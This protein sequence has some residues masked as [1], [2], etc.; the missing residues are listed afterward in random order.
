[1][2]FYLLKKI[3]L[4]EFCGRVSTHFVIC[5]MANTSPTN[6]A[7]RGYSDK[8]VE[9]THS[10]K[11]AKL[12][13]TCKSA[14]V[15]FSPRRK[16]PPEEDRILSNFSKFLGTCSSKNSFLN[17]AFLSWSDSRKKANQSENI[18]NYEILKFRKILKYYV[19]SDKCRIKII[20]NGTHAWL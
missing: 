16:S 5:G 17:F 2:N 7:S 4:S 18:C 1:M 8:I 12:W 14:Q 19:D 9:S 20:P 13:A 3:A 15:Y 11:N 10:S 6:F